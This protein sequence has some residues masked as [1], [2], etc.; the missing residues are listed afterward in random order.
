[1][2]RFPPEFCF[3][4]EHVFAG[5]VKGKVYLDGVVVQISGPQRPSLQHQ[6]DPYE[7]L[8][9]PYIQTTLQISFPPTWASSCTGVL[10]QIGARLQR[11]RE[12]YGVY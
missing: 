3:R 5:M 4:L 1:M 6:V 9:L 11:H 10:L 7:G 2:Q 8:H 12:E